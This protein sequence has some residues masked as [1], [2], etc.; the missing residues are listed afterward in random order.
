MTIYRSVD[1]L[2]VLT[3]GKAEFCKQSLESSKEAMDAILQDLP[4]GENRTIRR[5]QQTGTSW[6]PLLSSTI[7]GIELLGQEFQDAISM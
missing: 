1:H 3:N 6:L 4:T 7:N 5:G 2:S